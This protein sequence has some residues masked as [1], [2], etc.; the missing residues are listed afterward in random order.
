LRWRWELFQRKIITVQEDR[1]YTL[2]SWI[3]RTWSKFEPEIS[4]EGFYNSRVTVLTK[5]SPKA[6]VHLER[7]QSCWRRQSTLLEVSGHT[8]PPPFSKE[9]A[10][11]RNNILSPFDFFQYAIKQFL[12]IICMPCESADSIPIKSPCMWV[13][14]GPI[15]L[16]PLMWLLILLLVPKNYASQ[17]PTS[18]TFLLVPFNGKCKLGL[19]AQ[20]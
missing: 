13:L 17:E 11:I 16:V 5:V 20:F 6:A 14:Y 15:D 8:I 1:I 7:I 10:T 18:A 3:W 19:A 9:K 2:Y 12:R 4:E